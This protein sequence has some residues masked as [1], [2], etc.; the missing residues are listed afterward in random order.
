MLNF[1]D[2]FAGEGFFKAANYGLLILCAIV[3]FMIGKN[4]LNTKITKRILLILVLAD[5]I[6]LFLNL[7]FKGNFLIEKDRTYPEI[8]RY[9][10]TLACSAFLWKMSL[11]SKSQMLASFSIFFILLFIDD[12][13]TLHEN[14]GFLMSGTAI[15]T[16]GSNI[17]HVRSNDVGEMAYFLMLG[18]FFLSVGIYSY[19]KEKV[20]WN[21]S[22]AEKITK[23]MLLGGFIS[24]GSDMV[25]QM[26]RNTVIAHH[27][28]GLFQSFSKMLFLSLLPA[29]CM[30]L[31]IQSKNISQQASETTMVSN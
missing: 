29:V 26:L 6:F 14:I 18:V 16:A 7:I 5:V 22:V 3:L 25:N 15:A 23:V 9:L 10:E 21:R 17:L 2:L 4:F 12:C 28:F 8:F 13:F 30:D 19:C 24:V 11:K 1:N 27:F 31:F 20:L